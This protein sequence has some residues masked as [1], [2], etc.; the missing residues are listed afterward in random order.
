MPVED[1]KDRYSANMEGEYYVTNECMFCGVC[2]QL[3][4]TVFKFK[5]E[6]GYSFVIKQ[7]ETKEENE[8][9]IEALESCFTNAIFNDGNT[10]NW[11][12]IP[13][14]PNPE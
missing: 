1:F 13:S 8:L 7:P 2:S 14:Q 3:A 12:N 11:N 9:A 5:K 6:E 10:F 4:P